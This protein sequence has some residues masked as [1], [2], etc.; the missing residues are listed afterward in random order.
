M[1]NIKTNMNRQNKNRT[2]R[3][4]LIALFVALIAVGAFIKFPIGIVPVSMQCAFCIL[5]ALMLG[6]K[7][8]TISVAIYLAMGLVGIPIFTAGGGFSYVLQ[9]TFGYL[10]GYIFALP[11]GALVARGLS[12]T[13]RPKL[14]RLLLGA[15]TALT[16]VYTFGVMYMY[17]MLNFYMGKAIDIGKAWMTGCAVFLPTDVCWCI[18]ASLVAHRVVPLVF[19]RSV[20]MYNVRAYLCNEE[21]VRQPQAQSEA[22]EL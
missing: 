9:P 5:C 3:L 21:Y 19:K 4:V 17:L 7:D 6:A 14:W 12:N 11:A 18:V 8:A 10:L 20:G 2:L 15:F 1:E 13:S 16:I 22:D